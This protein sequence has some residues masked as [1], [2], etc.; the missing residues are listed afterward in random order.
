MD[1]KDNLRDGLCYETSITNT[2][3]EKERKLRERLENT[4]TENMDGIRKVAESI[5]VPVTVSRVSDNSVLYANVHFGRL[6]GL[7]SGQLVGAKTSVVCCSPPDHQY[8]LRDAIKSAGYLH[9]EVV[10]LKKADGTFVRSVALGL[11]VRLR[12]GNSLFV[13]LHY[14]V[15]CQ[16]AVEDIFRDSVTRNTK[17]AFQSGELTIDFGKRRVFLGNH[18][19]YLTGTEYRLLTCLARCAGSV[20][21]ADELLSLV[22]GDTYV[23]DRNL[24]EINIARIRQKL[25]D[26]SRSPRYIVTRTGFGYMFALPAKASQV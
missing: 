21:T 11:P 1:S 9:D 5:P 10:Y 7:V 12:S 19:V 13:C 22:W 18:E 26:N 4:L 8:R 23:G 24:V 2:E 6:L 17:P 15:N 20:M 25:N 14:P 16:Q 3:V